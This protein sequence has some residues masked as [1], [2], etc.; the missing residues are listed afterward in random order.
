MSRQR[1]PY[2]ITACNIIKSHRKYCKKFKHK[3]ITIPIGKIDGVNL[4]CR[5]E[6]VYN[7]STGNVSTSSY[8]IKCGKT[9]IIYPSTHQKLKCT[10]Q[11]AVDMVNKARELQ[12]KYY[13]NKTKI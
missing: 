7:P 1:L 6:S 13:R 3:C 5:T 9:T 11:H 4:S 2:E 12:K 8:G 10:N